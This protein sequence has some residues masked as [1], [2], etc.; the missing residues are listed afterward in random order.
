MNDPT[1]ELPVPGSPE[2][3]PSL[4]SGLDKEGARY[5][6][7]LLG[8]KFR[9]RVTR[10][11]GNKSFPDEKGLRFQ[12]QDPNGHMLPGPEVGLHAIDQVLAAIAIAAA[13]H[14]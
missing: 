7:V 12:L 5:V 14:R 9:F 2:D 8:G 10:T 13:G 6:Q 3:G 11:T 4:T 1:L